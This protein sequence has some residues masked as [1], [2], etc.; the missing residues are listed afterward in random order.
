[1]RFVV[2]TR[3][4]SSAERS[5]GNQAPGLDAATWL[6]RCQSPARSLRCSSSPTLRWARRALS[7]MANVS[8]AWKTSWSTSAGMNGAS[9]GKGFFSGSR[10]LHDGRSPRLRI[11]RTVSRDSALVTRATSTSPRR[12]AAA[13]SWTR[14]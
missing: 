4:I 12:I 2:V 5:T 10:K 13:A 1:M 3:R 11:F 8:H 6:K 7:N 9:K 14:T